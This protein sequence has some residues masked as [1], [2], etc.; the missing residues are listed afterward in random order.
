[1]FFSSYLSF[2]INSIFNF[3]LYRG[4]YYFA[5]VVVALSE[6]VVV[7]LSE[8]VVVVVLDFV[9]DFVELLE[10]LELLPHAV[11][12]KAITP[13]IAN[14]TIFLLNFLIPLISS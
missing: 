13:T 4:S 1:M 14:I 2:Y 12:A 8:A 7:V 11:I 10:L 9:V 6:A 5:A 3:K